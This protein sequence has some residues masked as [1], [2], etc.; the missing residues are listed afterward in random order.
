MHFVWTLDRSSAG[1]QIRLQAFEE[2]IGVIQERSLDA[3]LPC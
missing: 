3:M 2:G 1:Q